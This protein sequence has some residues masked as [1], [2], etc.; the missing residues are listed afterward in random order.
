MAEKFQFVPT[1][2]A[3]LQDRYDLVVIGSGGTGLVA[4]MQAHELGLKPVV[5]EK[6]PKLGGNTN[7]ASSGMNAAETNVQLHNHV[8]DSYEEFYADT[9][10]GGGQLNNPEMLRYFTSHSALAI[11]WLADHG[12][13][14]DDLTVTGGMQKKRTHRPSSMAPIGGFL[15]TELLKQIQAEKVPVFTN[16]TVTKLNVTD[17]KVTGVTVKDEQADGV[18]IAADAVVLATGGFGANQKLIGKYREDLV[19]YNTTNQPGATGDGIELA[20]AAGAALVDMDQ[21]QVHPTVQQDT[22]HAFLIGEAVRGEGA[23]LVG[24]DGKRFVNELDTRKNVT[25]AINQLPEKSAYLIFDTGIR[26]RV[27]AVEFY[28]HIGLVKHGDSIADLAQTLNMDADTLSSTVTTWNQAVAGQND[29]DF[30]RNMGMDRDISAGPFFA[31]HIAPAIH[32]TMGGIKI[33]AQTQVLKEDGTTLSGLFAAGE[34][35]GGLHGNNRIGGNSIAETVVFGRQAGEQVYTY[36]K[37]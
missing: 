14:L 34:V 15:V 20:T 28:D 23:I 21:I 31:I 7:R 6:M 8:V 32:Y 3:E 16:V 12:I 9:F 2:L 17:D 25:N 11:D 5:L 24:A 22:D 27:K 19:G 13:V 18:Q 29:T 30:G 10:K 26:S 36:L 4:A 35:A 1:D 33:N 37:D